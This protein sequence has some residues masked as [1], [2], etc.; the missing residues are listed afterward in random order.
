MLTRDCF[1]VNQ[2]ALFHNRP[3]LEV[4]DELRFDRVLAT[5]EADLGSEKIQ[6][7]SSQPARPVRPV[8][9]V[10]LKKDVPNSGVPLSQ[11]ISESVKTKR[12]TG[13]SRPVMPSVDNNKVNER[14]TKITRTLASNSAGKMTG[15]LSHKT[16]KNLSP[17]IS[18]I[19]LDHSSSEVSDEFR[20]LGRLQPEGRAPPSKSLSQLSSRRPYQPNIAQRALKTE[21]S[22]NL[23]IELSQVLDDLDEQNPNREASSPVLEGIEASDLYSSEEEEE[24]STIN[25]IKSTQVAAFDSGAEYGPWSKEAYDLFDVHEV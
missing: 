9:K 19:D 1:D 10:A 15:K 11:I 7:R 3:S 16:V 17:E 8:R 22:A 20:E 14:G 12:G 5:V 23:E 18:P 21:S 25:T 2:A 13:A 6:V 24:D 4:G